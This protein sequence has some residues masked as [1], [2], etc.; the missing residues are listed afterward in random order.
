MIA[1][2]FPIKPGSANTGGLEAC[3]K[4][5][6]TPNDADDAGQ[7]VAKGEAEVCNFDLVQKL[8]YGCGLHGDVELLAKR[9]AERESDESQSQNIQTC[10]AHIMLRCV[11]QASLGETI[12]ELSEKLS[13][14]QASKA[15]QRADALPCVQESKPGFCHQRG[16]CDVEYT[17]SRLSLI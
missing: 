5:K 12:D 9:I 7:G 17:W 13:S 11:L 16:V 2:V 8:P 15:G 1:S 3:Q 6:R 4:E 14:E 10:V